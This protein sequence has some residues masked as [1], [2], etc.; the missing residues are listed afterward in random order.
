M[1][2]IATQLDHRNV[3]ADRDENVSGVR[4]KAEIV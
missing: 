1:N 4:N 2:S 3:Q